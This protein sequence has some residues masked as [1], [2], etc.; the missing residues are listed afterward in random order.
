MLFHVQ[1]YAIGEIYGVIGIKNLAKRRFEKLAWASWECSTFPVAIQAIYNT[2]MESDRGL[3]DVAVEVA[4]THIGKLLEMDGYRAMMDEVGPFGK[5]IARNLFQTPSAREK[6]LEALVARCK[7]YQCP[8][9]G[10]TMEMVLPKDGSVVHCMR[11]GRG[12]HDWGDNEL[13]EL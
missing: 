6:E 9:C 7:T 8:K 3:R 10:Y 4:T 1:T 12:C 11:C 5:E 13:V 2:T